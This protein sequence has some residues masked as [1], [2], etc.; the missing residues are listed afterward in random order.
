MNSRQRNVEVVGPPFQGRVSNANPH[1]LPAGSSLLQT[2]IGI[3]SGGQL[4]VRRGN[5]LSTFGNATT[6]VASNVVAVHGYNRPEGRYIVYVLADAS[7][8]AG[9]NPT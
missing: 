4:D 6:A 2:N 3:F 7:V 9:R 8:K 1:A 5:K